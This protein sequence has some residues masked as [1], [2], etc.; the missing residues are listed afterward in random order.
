MSTPTSA[1][2]RPI[3]AAECAERAAAVL[4]AA[5]EIATINA[6]PSAADQ[7]AALALVADGW[8]NLGVAMT[9]HPLARPVPNDDR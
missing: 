5:E 8:R 7:A 3:T 1:V 2:A 6:G 4:R 9:Q